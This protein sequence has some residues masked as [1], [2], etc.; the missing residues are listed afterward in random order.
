M[1]TYQSGN[2]R[3]ATSNSVKAAERSAKSRQCPKCG[4]KSA[5]KHYSGGDSVRVLVCMV[6][7]LLGLVTLNVYL[8]D[9]WS[10]DTPVAY[11]LWVVWCLVSGWFAGAGAGWLGILWHTRA[12]RRTPRCPEASR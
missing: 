9:M 12:R 7:G 4:R 11:V 3:K 8:A 6:S 2:V 5:L 1:A 10:F